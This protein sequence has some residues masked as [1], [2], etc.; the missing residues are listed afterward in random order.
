MKYRNHRSRQDLIFQSFSLGLGGFLE[1][2]K[3]KEKDVSNEVTS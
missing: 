3:T 1:I 2:N